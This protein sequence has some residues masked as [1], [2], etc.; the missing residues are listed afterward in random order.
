MMLASIN[1]TGATGGTG[2]TT[3]CGRTPYLPLALIWVHIAHYLI[4]CV[5]P[6]L[7]QGNTK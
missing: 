6:L 7:Q 3:K 4:L 1:M 5:L 2:T